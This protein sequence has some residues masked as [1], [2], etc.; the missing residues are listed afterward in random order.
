MEKQEDLRDGG[1]E[2]IK[3]HLISIT[4]WPA[5]RQ[6]KLFVLRQ[7]LEDTFKDGDPGIVIVTKQIKGKKKIASQYAFVLFLL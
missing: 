6:Q 2:L 5:V 3:Q 1:Q 4:F 7:Y